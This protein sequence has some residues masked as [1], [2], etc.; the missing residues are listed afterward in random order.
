MS[1]GSISAASLSQYV[2][3]S[4]NSSTLQQTLQSLQNSLASGNLTSAQSSFQAL[5]NIS[6][7]S[8]TTAGTSLSSNTQYSSDLAALGSALSSGDLSTAQSTFATVLGDLKNTASPAQTDE[9]T[10]A[11]QSLN[12]VNELLSTLTPNASS[13]ATPINSDLTSPILENFYASKSGL[14]VLA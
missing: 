5:Q 3:D 9:A 13:G 1:V 6:E 12:L 11:A 14:N 4:S 2:F 8:A 7:N 10:A